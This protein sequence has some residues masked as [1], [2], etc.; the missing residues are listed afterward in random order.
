MGYTIGCSLA[1]QPHTHSTGMC[2]SYLQELDKMPKEG[3]FP[4]W[5]IEAL[6]GHKICTVYV[7]QTVPESATV[8][9]GCNAKGQARM[10]PSI[11]ESCTVLMIHVR[12]F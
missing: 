8:H 3:V 4:M 7:N 10:G 9:K 2:L 11:S 5:Y 1:L 6:R 12:N